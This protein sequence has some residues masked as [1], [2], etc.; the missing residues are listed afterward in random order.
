[1]RRI[2]LAV[3]LFNG[4]ACAGFPS[5]A[6]RL[7]EQC[8]AAGQAA[9]NCAA[10]AEAVF[11]SRSARP[12]REVRDP[13]A[14]EVA[15]QWVWA[16]QCD[17]GHEESCVRLLASAHRTRFSVER[18]VDQEVNQMH[19]R[20]LQ[21]IRAWGTSDRD[22]IVLRA[23]N[24]LEAGEE[25]FVYRALGARSLV[26][27][28]DGLEPRWSWI[29]TK[30][31]GTTE[32]LRARER[33]SSELARFRRQTLQR[34]RSGAV[35]PDRALEDL[36]AIVVPTAEHAKQKATLVELLNA[37]HRDLKALPVY[38][39]IR[40]GMSKRAATEARNLA[41]RPV[42]YG[43][44]WCNVATKA[45]E[46]DFAVWLVENRVV[47]VR[48]IWKD[49]LRVP[50]AQFVKPYI[51]RYGPPDAYDSMPIPLGP[52]TGQILTT[53]TWQKPNLVQVSS[54]K[55]GA[56]DEKGF[57]FGLMLLDSAKA[58]ALE[59]AQIAWE[60]RGLPLAP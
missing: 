5:H 44:T 58:E 9:D 40:L 46:S 43:A 36:A 28:T 8:P 32:Q 12:T 38:G 23:G 57:G 17:R 15:A 45:K 53:T 48:V 11:A 30:D 50:H 56:Y 59:K 22:K 4:A 14:S 26:S 39:G 60:K 25:V 34:V 55:A 33:A 49:S 1:M 20:T 37:I 18:N 6:K 51:E 13:Y 31:L 27:W 24:G 21:L 3:L 41:C 54:R 35:E 2:Q 42:R 47:Y 52:Y 19:A 16:S 10:K 29:A 7:L